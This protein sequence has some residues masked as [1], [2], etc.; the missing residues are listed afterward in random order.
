MTG[1][2]IKK[3]YLPIV[4]SVSNL[5]FLM[6]Q[7]RYCLILNCTLNHE[8]LTFIT[9]PNKIDPRIFHNRKELS[10]ADISGKYRMSAR[11]PLAHPSFAKATE[12]RRARLSLELANL[13]DRP[14]L[15]LIRF[16]R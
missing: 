8:L 7:P 3:R 5:F 16:R 4:R 2:R 14:S 13:R 9:A 15:V 11:G 1:P 6:F 10:V 12:G